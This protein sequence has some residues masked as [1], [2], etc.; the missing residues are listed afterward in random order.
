[1][2]AVW[3][4]VSFGACFF[5]RDLQFLVAGWPFHYW[6]AAQGALL[7]FVAI[8]VVYAVVANR[9]DAADEALNALRDKAQEGSNV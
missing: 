3:A 9:T 6:L 7:A 4:A 5:A 1:M 8:V 2:L